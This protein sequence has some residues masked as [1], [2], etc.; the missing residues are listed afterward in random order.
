LIPFFVSTHN[1]RSS[2]ESGR[3]QIK[4]KIPGETYS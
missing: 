1:T 4:P 3:K 2:A